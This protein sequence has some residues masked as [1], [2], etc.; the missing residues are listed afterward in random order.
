M[1]RSGNQKLV[2]DDAGV[3]IIVNHESHADKRF[4]VAGDVVSLQPKK[5]DTRSSRS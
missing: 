2:E 3:A 5:K 1:G 4:V